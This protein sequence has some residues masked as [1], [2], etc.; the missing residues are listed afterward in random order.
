MR[1][2]LANLK[3]GV[4]KTTTAVNL[5][6][7]FARS[8]L[9]TLL[10]DLDPQA[11]ASYSLGVEREQAEVSAA[12]VLSDE[13]DAQGRTHYDRIRE[14]YRDHPE[15]AKGD[16]D[17]DRYYDRANDRLTDLFYKGDRSMRESG[18]DP[19][20]RFGPFSADIVHHVPVCLN[21]LLYRM[22]RDAAD[23]HS[24]LGR[25]VEALS[26]EQ[27][28]A[29]RVP[30]VQRDRL[31]AAVVRQEVRAHVRLA[32][33]VA[34][35]EAIGIRPRAV[36]DAD[37]ARAVAGEPVRQER[38]RGRL[39]E[40]QHAQALQSAAHRDGRRSTTRTALPCGRSMVPGAQSCTSGLSAS[41]S[42][43][44]RRMRAATA[45]S[46]PAS[47]STSTVTRSPPACASSTIW[48]SGPTPA[49]WST[50]RSTC[51]G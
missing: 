31:L 22:E 3:G 29:A 47:A 18:F 8:G 45:G 2:A 4:G 34:T 9:T 43:S 19:S 13:K 21:A 51:C 28:A 5:A 12:E 32:Q 6:A 39:L 24:I 27:R 41:A 50:R 49:C 38:Q 20:N 1:V 25:K 44:S 14:Y 26:W 48:Y 46:Q 17:V 36:L 15:A 23:I 42:C 7:A 16:Y 35:D 33:Q 10:I 37:D 30:E 11:S 40:R